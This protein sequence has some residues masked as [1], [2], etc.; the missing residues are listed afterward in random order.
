MDHK[1]RVQVAGIT[2]DGRK[3]FT[4]KWKEPQTNYRRGRV[5]ET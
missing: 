2:L 4:K 5:L 1:F 3:A